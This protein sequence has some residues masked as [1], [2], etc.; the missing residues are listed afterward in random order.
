[1]SEVTPD[2]LDRIERILETVTANQLSL[3]E[4][5]RQNTEEIHS[6]TDILMHSIQNA[7]IDREVFQAEIRRIWE[8]LLGQQR[9]NG[10]GEG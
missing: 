1:M 6:L 10:R 7:E 9:G 2:R 4:A 5:V 8:Y 3:Q